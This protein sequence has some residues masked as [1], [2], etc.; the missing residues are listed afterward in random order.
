MT[1]ELIWH[2]EPILHRAV[3]VAAFTGWFDIAGGATAAVRHLGGDDGTAA[4]LHRPGRLL[5]LHGPA[6]DGVARR[7]R[8]AGGV[9]AAQRGPAADG[10]GPVRRGRRTTW[11]CCRARSPTCAGRTFAGLVVEVVRRLRCEM[12][13]TVGTVA[14]TQPAHP[15]PAGVRQLDQRGAGRPA[16][17]EPAPLRGPDR[18]GRR[19]ARPARPR[20]GPGHL[21]ARA[22][23]PLPGRR[24]RTRSPPWPCS[25]T[26]STCWGCRPGTARWRPRWRS[27]TAA[28]RRRSTPTTTR[29][30]TSASW[31]GARPAA[32]RR[33]GRR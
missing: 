27:G 33:G 29:R 6:T 11:C 12:V 3:L 4:G 32:G 13:V 26:S 24:R 21:A 16:G 1:D 7:R 22:G 10:E 19:P 5:R 30:P 31:S 17:A 20:R 15:Q 14:D 23:P 8:S 25:S 28:T 9:V 18:R 2:D